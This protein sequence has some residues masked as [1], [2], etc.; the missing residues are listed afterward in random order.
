MM[1]VL[2]TAKLAETGAQ[3]TL[4]GGWALVFGALRIW[5]TWRTGPRLFLMLGVAALALGLTGQSLVR[6]NAVELNYYPGWKAD[7]DQVLGEDHAEFEYSVEDL[8][9]GPV[10]PGQWEGPYWWGQRLCLLLGSMG[11]AG[12]FLL[13]GREALAGKSCLGRG[14]PEGEGE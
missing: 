5:R 8:A 14:E 9:I 6:L 3:L 2:A 10:H 4:L 1:E 12:G 13:L 7:M 11:A